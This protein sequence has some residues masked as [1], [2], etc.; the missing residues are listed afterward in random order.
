MEG[1]CSVSLDLTVVV[2]NRLF[3]SLGTDRLS[4]RPRDVDFQV[5][6][7]QWRRDHISGGGRIWRDR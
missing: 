4:V 7:M 5:Y 1:S 2:L 6:A 3:A